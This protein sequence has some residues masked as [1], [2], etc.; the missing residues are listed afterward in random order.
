MQTIRARL[1]I[2]LCGAASSITRI[3]LRFFT[4]DISEVLEEHPETSTSAGGIICVV[5]IA[6]LSKSAAIQ[7]TATLREQLKFHHDDKSKIEDPWR[8][9]IPLP[10][11]CDKSGKATA[12]LSRT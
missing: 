10:S 8:M 9:L 12:N 11:C 3:L 2:A 5:F 1:A 4:K 6:S 7:C